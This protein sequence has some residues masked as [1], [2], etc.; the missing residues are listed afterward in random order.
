M[1]DLGATERMLG[2]RQ[3]GMERM[4]LGLA[5]AEERLGTRHPIVASIYD[6]FSAEALRDG[7]F[8][9]AH[10]WALRS[11]DAVE[12]AYG[13]GSDERIAVEAN[14]CQ[15]SQNLLRADEAIEH[16]EAA[17][18]LGN[19]SSVQD[20]LKLA[21][22]ENNL[23]AALVSAGRHGEAPPHFERALSLS[24]EGSGPNSMLGAVALANIAEIRLLE[25][26][27]TAALDLY[28]RSLGMREA[29]NGDRDPSLVTPLLGISS[30]SLS[31]GDRAEAVR[32]AER[33]LGIAE[34]T[35]G[36]PRLL[37]RASE[38]LA[39][40]LDKRPSPR[41]DRTRSRAFMQQALETF[42]PLGPSTAA[43]VSR[44]R[45]WLEKH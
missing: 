45:A 10:Q 2:A 12:A 9:E 24:A 29:L 17:A 21:T 8:E 20:P 1:I 27:A 4:R 38:A 15:T 16:C 40:A 3:A 43:D 23:G 22:V 28:R 42:E 39:L 11:R 34:D 30:A 36:D 31:L 33:A 44:V 13:I 7:H 35:G 14:L 32:T 26:T 19:A 41:S 25:G 5:L 37:A 18:V 6:R